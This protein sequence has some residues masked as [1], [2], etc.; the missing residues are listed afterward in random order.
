MPHY[1][2]GFLEYMTCQIMIANLVPDILAAILADEISSNW[3]LSLR[4]AGIESYKSP[5]R[6]K[7]VI[8]KLA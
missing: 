6:L 7:S 2:L 4:V 5:T 8:R 1:H 3:I